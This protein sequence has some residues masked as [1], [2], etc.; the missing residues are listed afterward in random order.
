MM[1]LPAISVPAIRVFSEL[2][3]KWQQSAKVVM[4]GNLVPVIATSQPPTDVQLATDPMPL[5]SGYYVMY[6]EAHHDELSSE[7]P[8]LT[9]QNGFLI[10]KNAPSS[11]DLD[12]RAKNAVPGVSYV[13]L[14]IYASKA[15]LGGCGGGSAAGKSPADKA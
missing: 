5:T 9:V 8:N 13:S 14:R 3:G 1:T 11:D 15:P 6:P 12:T 10:H 7:F 2:F 4:N